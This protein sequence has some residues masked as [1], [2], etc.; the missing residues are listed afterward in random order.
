MVT[1]TSDDGIDNDGNTVDDPTVIEITKQ[2]SVTIA[3]QR[4]LVMLTE[5]VLMELGI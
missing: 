1:E 3:K 2:S 5:T 4:L